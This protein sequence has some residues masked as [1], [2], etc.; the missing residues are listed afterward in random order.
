MCLACDCD[1][2]DV[3]TADSC[4]GTSGACNNE[5]IVNCGV[6]TIPSIT[7][8]GLIWFV[9][10]LILGG[11]WVLRPRRGEARSNN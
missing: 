8:P 10:V 4:D 5:P 3:C 2:Q 7:F 1:D 9:L 11:V 6:P